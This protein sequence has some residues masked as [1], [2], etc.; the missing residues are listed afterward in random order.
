MARAVKKGKKNRKHNRNRDSAAMKRYRNE[1]RRDK[2]K[3]LKLAR[4]LKNHPNDNQ[5]AKAA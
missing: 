3:K 5:S 1:G 4:H 2:N